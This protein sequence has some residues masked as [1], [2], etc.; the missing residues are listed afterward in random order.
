MPISTKHQ[1]WGLIGWLAITFIAAAVGASA[2]VDAPRFYQTLTLP[3]WAPSSSVFGPVWTL[4]YFMMALAA[5]LVWRQ[6][7]LNQARTALMLYVVQLVFNALWSWAFFAWYQGSV[8][9]M[10]ISVLWLL[11]AITLYQF[12]NINRIAGVL[13]IPYLVWLTYA[14]TL[15]FVVWQTNPNLLGS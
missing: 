13:L 1:I 4:L 10:V 9:V 8:S 3:S 14:G 2:T 5:W 11:V 15:N 7:G 6:A 12:W